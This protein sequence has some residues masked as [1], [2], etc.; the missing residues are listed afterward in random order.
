MESHKTV[1]QQERVKERLTGLISPLVASLGLELWGIEIPASPKG[2]TLR[3]YIDGP[4]GVNV[5]Q[6]AEVSR[7]VSALLD[8]E[9][10]LPGPYTL[11][12]SSPGLERPFFSL[13]QM[14]PYAGELMEAKLKEPLE[15]R[16]KWRGVLL[17]ASGNRIRL[18]VEG[19]KVDLPWDTIQKVNLKYVAKQ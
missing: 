7:H 5:D 18:E 6:C 9:D 3:L 17:E 4:G 2:G 13:E 1:Y 15:G 12:V 10:P 14:D 8:A 16:K 19:R 11:E